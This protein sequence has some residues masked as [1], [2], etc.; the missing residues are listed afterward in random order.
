[1]KY[2]INPF[3]FVGKLD[4]NYFFMPANNTEPKAF[5]F[6]ENQEENLSKLFDGN[7]FEYDELCKI[8]TKEQTDFFLNNNILCLENPDT[9]GINSR[10]DAF[11][12]TYNMPQA[13]EYLNQKHILILGCGGIGTHMAWHM[14]ALGVGKLT[15]LDFDTVERSNF[16]RQILFNNDDIGQK[17]VSVLSAK[18]SKINDEIEINIIDKRIDCVETLEA[19]CTNDHYDLIIKSLD[20][21]ANVSYWL[22]LVC[23]KHSLPYIAGIT[24]Q[25]NALIG[26]TF[27]PGKSEVG[28]SDLFYAPQSA[29]KIHGT[30]PSIG[31]MLYHISSELAIEAFKF[32]TGCGELKYCGKISFVDIFDNKEHSLPNTSTTTNNSLKESPIKSK[33]GFVIGFFLIL[34]LSACSFIEFWFSIAAFGTAMIL[35]FY[36][37]QKKDNI[38]KCTL[39]FSM[40]FSLLFGLMLTRNELLAP[41]FNDSVQAFSALTIVFSISGGLILLMCILNYL[42]SKIIKR[43]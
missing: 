17:K 16:N 37:Y 20:S 28:W 13:R 10:T 34:A 3:A 35:P 26:P 7:E 23:K 22:D 42:I 27:I 43:R 31:I 6:T 30:A 24:L 1:M 9:E 33:K 8:Y 21:P 25:K 18:L 19:V 15:L 39:V 32:L 4:D 5:V 11:F 40:L 14:V 36:L 29:E 38:L 41:F 2:K 12:S